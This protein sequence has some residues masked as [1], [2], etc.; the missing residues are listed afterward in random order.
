MRSTTR[1]PDELGFEGRD[2]LISSEEGGFESV[3]TL[4]LAPEDVARN[5]GTTHEGLDEAD[6]DRDAHDPA[7]GGSDPLQ[8]RHVTRTTAEDSLNRRPS[9]RTIAPTV[10][11]G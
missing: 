9:A 6:Q 8:W 5:Q 10:R 4:H 3:A 7:P 1:R 2:S 11:F